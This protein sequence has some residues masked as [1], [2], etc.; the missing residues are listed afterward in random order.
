MGIEPTTFAFSHGHMVGKQRTTI[1]LQRR[2][3]SY[4]L[5][6]LPKGG[7]RRRRRRARLLALQSGARVR[8]AQLS[9]NDGDSD[10]A[11]SLTRYHC[12]AM[13][14]CFRVFRSTI[15]CDRKRRRKGKHYV[16]HHLRAVTCGQVEGRR[17]V[18]HEG[19]PFEL[20]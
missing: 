14:L 5:N 18:G 2:C 1:V 20:G 10:W 8:G 19:L 9:P 17:W 3:L 4:R 7:R 6:P 15:S 12:A 13:A 11:E 16:C